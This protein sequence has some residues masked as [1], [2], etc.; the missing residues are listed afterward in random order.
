M[1]EDEETNKVFT[2]EVIDLS[3]EDYDTPTTITPP[4]YFLGEPLEIEPSEDTPEWLVHQVYKMRDKADEVK[5]FLDLYDRFT[6]EDWDQTPSEVKGFLNHHGY[7]QEEDPLEWLVSETAD[8]AVELCEQRDL[9]SDVYH[10]VGFIPTGGKIGDIEPEK[11]EKIDNQLEYA[12]SAVHQV[13]HTGATTEGG[14]TEPYPSVGVE[15]EH[16]VGHI[17]KQK[18]EEAAEDVD[19]YF[20]K[21]ATWE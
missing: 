16:S 19:W 18:L 6:E 3:D 17:Y 12:S 14:W 2:G 4:K 15:P 1:T 11:A 13:E 7:N 5:D 21:E 20:T 9:V 8:R 10:G